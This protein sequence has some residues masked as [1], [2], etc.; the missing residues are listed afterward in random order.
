MNDIKLSVAEIIELSKTAKEQGI[1]PNLPS[2]KPGVI[3][4]AER[5]EWD[6]EIVPAKGGRGGVKKVYTLPS[7]T[8]EGLREKGLLHL[9]DKGDGVPVTPR[10]KQPAPRPVAAG[11]PDSM[12]SMVAEY[13]DW[14]AEQDTD[15]IVPVRYHTNVFG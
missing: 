7:E 14:A 9:L 13:D 6:F 11:V 8:I 10:R 3:D 5:E 4:K 12:R 2:S 1:D 15:S